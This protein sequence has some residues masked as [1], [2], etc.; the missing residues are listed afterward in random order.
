MSIP[1]NFIYAGNPDKKWDWKFIPNTPEARQEAIKQGYNAFTPYSFDFEP[2]EENIKKYG[3]T[4]IKN[5]DLWIDFD[6]K[7]SPSEA[8]IAAREFIN[9][10]TTLYKIDKRMIRYF[11]SGSKGCHICIPAQ[12]YGDELGHNLLPAIHR[13]M[14]DMLISHQT[15]YVTPELHA[16]IYK[17]YIDNS[18]YCKGKGH[19]LREK[20][21]KRADGRY[22]VEV[23]SEKFMNGDI[24]QLLSL[25]KE[26]HI[27]QIDN[28]AP[29]QTELV[30]LFD[31]AT[32][33]TQLFENPQKIFQS[34]ITCKFMEYCLE[35]SK[36]LEEPM[37][38]LMLSVLSGLG[39]DTGM[40]LAVDFSKY[41][42]NFDDKQTREKFLN[43]AQYYPTCKHIKEH[44]QC[45][46]SCKRHNPE[47]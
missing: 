11:L 27:E 30:E 5:G 24:M 19:L 18:L 33:Y 12:I 46:A 10:T 2:T 9:E 25:T 34:L 28:I 1:S 26:N 32:L 22:K 15:L 21:I 45:P 20:N 7:K 39:I 41:Y 40:K 44:F 37:W 4:P 17:N 6:S 43:A 23:P 47:H 38:F 14:V 42:P 35:K 8:I 36:E 13:K 31:K 16:P 3:R 29:I